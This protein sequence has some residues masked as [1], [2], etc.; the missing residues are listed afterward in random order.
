MKI[1][2]AA[3]LSILIFVVIVAGATDSKAQAGDDKCDSLS[4][5]NFFLTVSAIKKLMDKHAVMSKDD[6]KRMVKSYNTLTISAGLFKDGLNRDHF[7]EDF[8][9]EFDKVFYYVLKK[10]Y[11][12][13]A[14]KGGTEYLSQLDLYIGMGPEYRCK[15]FYQVY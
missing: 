12:Y 1:N 3:F 4:K 6:D 13:V 11:S 5:R 8:Q 14:T 10:K 15:D 2:K 7:L 9:A